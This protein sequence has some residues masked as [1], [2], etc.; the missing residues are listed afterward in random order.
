MSTLAA[1]VLDII[2]TMSFDDV[3]SFRDTSHISR[4]LL[5]K[6]TEKVITTYVGKYGPCLRYKPKT[7]HKKVARLV[8]K[9]MKTSP[10]MVVDMETL[11]MDDSNAIDVDVIGII[12]EEN[13]DVSSSMDTSTTDGDDVV[14]TEAQS[15]PPLPVM[16]D[17]STGIYDEG[18]IGRS[19]RAGKR[20]R[21]AMGLI[22]SAKEY[23]TG[24]DSRRKACESDVER[25]QLM[26]EE[27]DIVEKL[28]KEMTIASHLRE[29][30]QQMMES[31]RREVR[32]LKEMHG[33]NVH[34]MK[35][36]WRM[37]MVRMKEDTE[38]DA[39]WMMK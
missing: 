36:K 31:H 5:R 22:M 20:L 9:M 18:W 25:M 29:V 13:D 8:E 23:W 27:N 24:L 35:R 17:V 33:R 7:F 2:T 39:E 28:L 14:I 1:R 16:I 19:M 32:L 6:I 34:E 37:E 26:L 38:D 4:G 12:D 11:R 15:Y 3:A 10:D 30:I 21:D